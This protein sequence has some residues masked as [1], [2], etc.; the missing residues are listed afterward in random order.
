MHFRVLKNGVRMTQDFDSVVWGESVH[1]R[2]GFF[3]HTC[4]IF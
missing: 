1:V 4:W 3:A 2:S